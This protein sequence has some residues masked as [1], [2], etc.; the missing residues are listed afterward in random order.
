MVVLLFR[1]AIIREGGSLGE[2]RNDFGG[3]GICIKFIFCVGCCVRCWVSDNEEK[4]S[5]FLFL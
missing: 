1:M 3:L 4:E 5:G 2:G